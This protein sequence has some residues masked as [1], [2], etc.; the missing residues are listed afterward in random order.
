MTIA[1]EFFNIQYY[2]IMTVNVM[3]ER[4]FIENHFDKHTQ[5]FKDISKEIFS[6]KAN[7]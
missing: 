5:S 3:K 6:F 2:D 4:G 1:S 7:M